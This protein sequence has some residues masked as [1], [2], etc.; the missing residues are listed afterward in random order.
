VAT[1]IL[2]TMGCY[3]DGPGLRLKVRRDHILRM[4]AHP[5]H[6][7]AKTNTALEPQPN[8]P[9]E[10]RTKLKFAQDLL[11]FWRNHRHR[12][13][14]HQENDAAE[15]NLYERARNHSGGHGFESD[16]LNILELNVPR[17]PQAAPGGAA[18][19][20]GV[21][22]LGLQLRSGQA[23]PFAAQAPAP[24]SGGQAP[25]DPWPDWGQEGDPAGG[26]QMR[27]QHWPLPDRYGQ[28]EGGAWVPGQGF[29]RGGPGTAG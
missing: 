16:V 6:A 5:D 13:L 4:L 25:E 27:H 15:T 9:P 29:G 19:P 21:G 10:T 20:S 28:R 23:G 7:Q 17:K 26:Q 1:V 11:Q 2:N 8:D 3:L 14:Q 22:M 18:G 24:P 12:K